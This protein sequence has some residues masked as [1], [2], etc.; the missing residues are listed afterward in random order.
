MGII[1]GEGD[2]RLKKKEMDKGLRKEARETEHGSGH[3]VER[4]LQR[5][6]AGIRKEAIL[7]VWC[8]SFYYACMY[9]CMYV[10]ISAI[11]AILAAASS[12]Y[13]PMSM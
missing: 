5:E 10:C 3:K 1:G 11:I 7:F 9:V 2:R 13:M 6:E 8:F 4:P 12:T